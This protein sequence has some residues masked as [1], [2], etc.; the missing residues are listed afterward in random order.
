MRGLAGKTVKSIDNAGYA[1][2]ERFYGVVARFSY[3]EALSSVHYLTYF[4]L[5][6]IAL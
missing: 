2:F 3:K 1:V 4:Y 6:P 5:L